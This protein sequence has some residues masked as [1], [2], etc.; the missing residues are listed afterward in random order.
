MIQ[1][2]LHAVQAICD[3]I[4]QAQMKYASA[5][6]PRQND[7]QYYVQID[8]LRSWWSSDFVEEHRNQTNL[9]GETKV[10]VCH[11]VE[12][13]LFSNFEISL[14]YLHLL[15]LLKF[16]RELIFVF[17]FLANVLFQLSNRVFGFNLSLLF[18]VGITQIYKFACDHVEVLIDAFITK[19][20]NVC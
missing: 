5:N 12:S 9:E 7:H 19:K 4:K 1:G 18:W 2:E 10:T 11:N 6:K 3:L 15:L 20:R 14:F 13:F 16:K 8:I 17:F